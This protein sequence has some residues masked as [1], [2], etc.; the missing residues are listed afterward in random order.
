MLNTF[1]I[2]LPVLSN[3]VYCR[4]IIMNSPYFDKWHKSLSLDVVEEFLLPEFPVHPL[5][6]RPWT[7][8][9]ARGM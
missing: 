9:K 5:S 8:A 2:T 1:N 3:Y 4:A 7:R 6:L